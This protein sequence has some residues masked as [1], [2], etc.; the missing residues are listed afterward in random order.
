MPV[1][2]G[3][4][5]RPVVQSGDL[6]FLQQKEQEGK[7]RVDEGS[8]TGTG[9]LASLTASSGKDMYLSSASVS[10]RKTGSTGASNHTV[11]L[12]VNGVVKETFTTF[13][14]ASA[15]KLSAY[16]FSTKG[17][18]V[19]PTEV[20]RLQ[21]TE[22]GTATQVEGTLQCWEESSGSQTF[23]TSTI[24]INT[25]IPSENEV[26]QIAQD[27]TPQTFT[28]TFS[29]KGATKLYIN[30]DIRETVPTTNVTV[31]AVSGT[32]SGASSAGDQDTS[33]NAIMTDRTS[34]GD[35]IINADFG[36]L[37]TRD[38]AVLF[39]PIGGL[40]QQLRYRVNTDGDVAT[41]TAWTSE[42]LFFSGA[43]GAK[44]LFTVGSGLNFRHAEIRLTVLNTNF[45]STHIFEVF[46]ANEGWGEIDLDLQMLD[47]ARSE[48]VSIP[49]QPA[50]STLKSWEG[51]TK[52]TQEV[53]ITMPN[54]SSQL[55]TVQNLNGKA[56][57]S[58]QIS[59]TDPTF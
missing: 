56:N 54:Q 38:L 57:Y 23:G 48:W 8:L 2:D 47:E 14:F 28:D 19:A 35:A 15:G 34:F 18:K 10:L 31:T 30:R 21:V 17:L 32:V 52:D 7:L 11:E 40:T 58:M 39:D 45:A 53:D 44:Q 13:E 12:Q 16:H 24:N 1:I 55:R 29:T 26:V 20:I 27:Y 6:A 46:D 22:L 36:S 50:F 5:T 41:P 3:R 59:K 51:D 33:T 4:G 37:S 25:G 43:G 42:V 9:T 49:D